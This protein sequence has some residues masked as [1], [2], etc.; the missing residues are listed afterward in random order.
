MSNG[1]FPIARA[2]NGD[3]DPQR[4]S[5]AAK[6]GTAG[7]LLKSSGGRLY[8]LD[9]VNVAATAYY[10]MVFNKATAPA[11]GDTPV[12]R[13]RLPVSSELALDLG[14]FGLACP[15]GIGFAISSTD[16]TLTLAVADDIHYAA[17]W[18]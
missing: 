5:S 3:N 9:V 1:I 14:A 15:L 13:R 8:R 10:L 16:G 7:I 2:A 18:K 4:T 17:W 11:N 6:V 12:W